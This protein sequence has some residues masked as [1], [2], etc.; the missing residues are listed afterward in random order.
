MEI[1]TKYI[2][3][4][5][6]NLWYAYEMVVPFSQLLH[7]MNVALPY[8]LGRRQEQQV[9]LLFQKLEGNYL[10]LVSTF[11]SCCVTDRTNSSLLHRLGTVGQIS[12]TYLPLS[13]GK[14]KPHLTPK[15]V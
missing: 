3:E 1:G 2:L 9:G 14:D 5:K 4:W 13:L 12:M 6:W 11:Y 8:Q 7:Y 10:T 15:A